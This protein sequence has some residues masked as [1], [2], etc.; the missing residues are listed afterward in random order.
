MII[1]IVI[2]IHVNFL[3]FVEKGG[4]KYNVNIQDEDGWAQLFFLVYLNL[5][6]AWL[7]YHIP[8]CF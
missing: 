1:I 2:I 3:Y 5:S 8:P 7:N 4:K 6:P